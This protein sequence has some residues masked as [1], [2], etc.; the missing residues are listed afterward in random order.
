MIFFFFL[1]SKYRTSVF[2]HYT[3]ER[4]AATTGL[5]VNTI[6]KHIGWLKA[7]GLLAKTNGNL[8]LAATR[9]VN[10][11][12]RLISVDTKPW[13]TWKQFENRVY[14]RIIKWNIKQQ[15]FH[16]TMKR[17]AG[18]LKSTNDV[19]ILKKYLDKYGKYTKESA[20]LHPI[21]SVRQLAKL[22]NR[23]QGWT[24]GMLFRLEKMK[25]IKR[26]QQIESLPGY[27]PPEYCENGYA[28]YNK[29]RDVTSI[30][31][32]TMIFVNY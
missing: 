4:L 19:R 1:K 16:L 28:Y 12:K 18:N 14:A 30:H 24:Q 31:H 23:S 21:N 29:R 11:G 6:R 2:Y 17:L 7:A 25:Y 27:V 5:S 13:T 20:A 32:G 15:A 9:K 8:W 26:K 3:P 10:P 22:F